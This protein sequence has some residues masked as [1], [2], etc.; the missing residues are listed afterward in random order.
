MNLT[1]LPCFVAVRDEI[2][3]RCRSMNTH[4]TIQGLNIEQIDDWTL[5]FDVACAN[6][7]RF[8]VDLDLIDLM[9]EGDLVSA[10]T[11]VLH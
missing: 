8:H 6:G 11:Q 4:S 5:R 1:T 10:L 9:I 7:E 2:N 3:E